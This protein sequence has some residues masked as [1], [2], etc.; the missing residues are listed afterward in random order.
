MAASQ[1]GRVVTVDRRN[2][3]IEVVSMVGDDAKKSKVTL[4]CDDG[5]LDSAVA[6]L[7]KEVTAEVKGGKFVS[8]KERPEKK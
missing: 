8:F 5:C 2:V 7:G 1:V 6:L 4:K 3:T